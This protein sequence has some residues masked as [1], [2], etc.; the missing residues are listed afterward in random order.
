MSSSCFVERFYNFPVVFIFLLAVFSDLI[1][2]TITCPNIPS[3]TVT[4]CLVEIDA[5][6]IIHQSYHCVSTLAPVKSA[7]TFD[8]RSVSPRLSTLESG[9]WDLIYALDGLATG[10]L[11]WVTLGS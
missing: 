6:Y 2:V 8:I 9:G 11:H 5:E 1:N 10:L 4:Q 3:P 7:D